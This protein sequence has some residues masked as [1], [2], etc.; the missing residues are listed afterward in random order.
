MA[1]ILKPNPASAAAAVPV[2]KADG[3]KPLAIRLPD[4]RM[5][6]SALIV[7]SGI[8]TLLLTMQG[9]REYRAFHGIPSLSASLGQFTGQPQDIGNLGDLALYLAKTDKKD[10]FR[11]G[12]KAGGE[13]EDVIS[14]KA[15]Q[16]AQDLH[17]VGISW[18][19]SPEAMIED[20]KTGRT[21]FVKRGELVNDMKVEMIHKDRVI[22][23]FESERIELR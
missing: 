19:V 20:S 14:S 5:I 22:L 15:A 6:N 13:V 10:I 11:M 4:I 17:L 2:K 8:I 1:D 7:L 9:I 3:V 23:R 18:S 21:F 16:A 12:H